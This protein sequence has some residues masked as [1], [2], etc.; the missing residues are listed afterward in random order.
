MDIK[1]KNRDGQ[2]WWEGLSKAQKMAVTEAYRCYDE[3]RE[4]G[5]LLIRCA[6]AVDLEYERMQREKLYE[7]LIGD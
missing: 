5:D 4:L 7:D 1:S 3:L 6:R 2:L